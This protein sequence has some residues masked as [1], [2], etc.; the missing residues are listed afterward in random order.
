MTQ[1]VIASGPSI[2]LITSNA[3]ISF[4][5]RARWYPPSEPCRDT[6]NPDFASLCSTLAISGA[7]MPY[8]SAIS[9]A[10][11]APFRAMR[12]QMLHGNQPVVGLL[13]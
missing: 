13:R 6:I 1:E 2:A 9:D 8:T 5:C 7:E 10:L 12:G 4:G 3:V 11:L